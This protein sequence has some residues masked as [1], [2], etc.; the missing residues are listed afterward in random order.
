MISEASDE[1]FFSVD[2]L[3]SEGQ[4]K[5][6][7]ES[8]TQNWFTALVE[9]GE[10][11][12]Q[13]QA[14]AAKYAAKVER[15]LALGLQRMAEEGV[16][17]PGANKFRVIVSYKEKKPFDDALN[18]IAADLRRRHGESTES[19]GDGLEGLELSEE[20]F[21][22]AFSLVEGVADLNAEGLLGQL[23]REH[24][25]TLGHLRLAHAAVVRLTSREIQELVKRED[26]ESITLDNKAMRQELDQS[27]Q[28]IHVNEARQQGLLAAGRGI[29]VAVLDGEVSK[30][31]QDLEDRVVHKRNYTAEEWGRGSK[32]GTHVAGIIAGNGP[33]YRGVAPQATIWNY[34]LFP[35][36]EAESTESAFQVVPEGSIGAEAIEDAV[37]D[38]AKIL[39]CS[40]GIGVEKL[41]G[42]SVW[43]LAAER[44]AKLGVVVCKSA[45]NK[46]PDPSSL[47]S[48]ADARGDV[49]VVGATSHNGTEITSFSS[50]GPTADGSTK[51][52]ICACGERIMS[53]SET[54][55][56]Y[57]ALSG[58]SMATPHVSGLAALLLER[59]PKWKA[60]DV[61]RALME[62]A[63]LLTSGDVSPNDQGKGLVNAVRAAGGT[64]PPSPPGDGGAAEGHPAI[65]K[66][67]D[68]LS[69]KVEVLSQKVS[70]LSSKDGETTKP[71]SPGKR[72]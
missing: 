3:E 16:P 47:T 30:I 4:L 9:A 8:V 27:T 10:E 26:V 59:H 49:I 44:A 54:G 34:K 57:R 13:A 58:T 32:H 23:E 60:A 53:A 46:G 31:H 56:G 35:T 5:Q 36:G 63:D 19:T 71:G 70:E 64:A 72:R 52:D 22:E 39:N 65:M 11:P 24:I 48:P 68:A 50:R 25:E 38:G 12:A 69:Q 29:V 21:N 61:K 28:A 15:Q 7:L 37:K 1:E 33:T 51:P 14:E 6:A 41:D 43:A 62:N 45:G 20:E 67:L 17:A 42:N 66:A 18:E 40:W 55:S 2:E